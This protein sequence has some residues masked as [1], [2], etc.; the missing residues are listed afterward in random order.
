MDCISL[1][2]VY[3]IYDF[4]IYVGKSDLVSC[5]IENRSNEA[6]TDLSC[7]EMNSFCREKQF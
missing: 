3:E 5:F 4:L 7:S 1:F 6:S 2:L